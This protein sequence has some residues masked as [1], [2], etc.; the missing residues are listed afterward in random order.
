MA[1]DQPLEILQVPNTSSS[2]QP[3]GSPVVLDPGTMIHQEIDD[4]DTVA[5]KGQ[6]EDPAHDLAPCKSSHSEIKDGNEVLKDDVPAQPDHVL[7]PGLEMVGED[8]DLAAFKHFGQGGCIVAF[9]DDL[10]KSLAI[11]LIEMTVTVY[12]NPG[13]GSCIHK[14]GRDKKS[15]N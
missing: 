6:S 14:R 7:Q 9:Y 11:S 15:S 4:F 2:R 1:R 5:A 12:I 13:I 8:E 10:H 3:N